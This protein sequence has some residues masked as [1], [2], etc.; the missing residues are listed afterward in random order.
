VS[1]VVPQAHI[2]IGH[3]VTCIA[4]ACCPGLR[5]REATG[6]EST[7]GSA[8]HGEADGVGFGLRFSDRAAAGG[9]VN[10]LLEAAVSGHIYIIGEDVLTESCLR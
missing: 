8:R 7:L 2:I 6:E 3:A 1:S 9:T 4:L 5:H 10:D